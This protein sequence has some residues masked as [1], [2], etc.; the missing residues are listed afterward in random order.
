MTFRHRGDI[1]IIVSRGGGQEAMQVKRVTFYR[2]IASVLTIACSGCP[3]LPETGNNTSIEAA[4]GITEPQL[5][6]AST[7]SSSPSCVEITQPSDSVHRAMFE[8]LNLYRIQNGL[9]PLNYSRKLETAGDAHVRDL[10]TRHFFEH[11]NPDGKS[12]A[13]RA[14]A[15]GFCHK[16]VGENI[17]A[18]QTSVPA[19]MDAWKNS[20]DHN[21]NMLEPDYSY[22][23]MGYYVDPT[24]RQYWGQEFAYDVPQ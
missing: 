6:S 24:G 13:D 7:S 18:G 8:A 4:L 19:V 9:K 10:Y 2:S 21:E 23:G 5:A 20:P 15:I 22:V 1:I 14:L 17:A 11:V 12:P 16:Y 3:S